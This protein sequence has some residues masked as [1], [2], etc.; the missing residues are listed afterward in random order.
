MPP[1]DFYEVLGVKRDADE[2]EIKRAFR[3]LARKYHPD[4]NP[5]NREAEQ[6]FK[7]AS[8]AYEVLSDAE[9]RVKYD[10]FGPAAQQAWSPAGAGA[11]SGFAWASPGFGNIDELLEE[12]LGGRGGKPRARRP[13]GQD[14]RFEVELTLEEAARGVTREVAV[15]VPQPCPQCRGAGLTGRGA[16]CASCGGSGQVEQVKRLQVRIPPGVNTGSRIRLAG[17][18]VAGGNLYLIPRIAPHPFFKRRGDDLY[19][20]LPVT[21]AEAALGSDVEVPTLNGKVK[22]KLPPGTSSAQRLRLAGK[23]MPRADG[24]GNGDLYVQARVLVPKNLTQEEKQL[25]ARLGTMRQESP[26]ANLRV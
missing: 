23:G 9:K 12:L 4:V 6:K 20:E 5:G 26:R 2:K 11:S 15:P 13:R 14:L 16:I 1:R 3:K 21:F 8:E 19:C 24:G 18:G 17:Q 25:I 10:Q 7:E 22:L